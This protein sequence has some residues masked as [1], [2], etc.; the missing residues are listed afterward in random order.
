MR[1]LRQL[2]QLAAAAAMAGGSGEA[3]AQF[4]QWKHGSA[5]SPATDDSQ[6]RPEVLRLKRIEAAQFTGSLRV[7]AG[8]FRAALDIAEQVVPARRQG[9]QKQREK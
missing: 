1:G 2:G 6:C 3:L 5:I 9:V 7:C 8:R 4:F